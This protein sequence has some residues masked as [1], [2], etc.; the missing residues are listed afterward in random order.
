M[1]PELNNKKL[2]LMKKTVAQLDGDNMKAAKG[3]SVF[4]SNAF[5]CYAVACNL[6]K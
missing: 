6:T 5:S 2:S 1:K 3:G 4:V